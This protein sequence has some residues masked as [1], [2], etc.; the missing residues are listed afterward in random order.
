[1]NE[2]ADH[3]QKY[4]PRH[5]LFL[6][7]AVLV[8]GYAIYL[9]YYMAHLPC[10]NAWLLFSMVW[11]LLLTVHRMANGLLIPGK[12]IFETADHLEGGNE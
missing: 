1:M 8:S 2:T 10:S 7:F 6:A 11:N 3:P 12:N 4:P 9:F 5:F